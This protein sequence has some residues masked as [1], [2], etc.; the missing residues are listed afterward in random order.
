MIALAA[1][2]AAHALLLAVRFAA[3]EVFRMQP[4]DPGLEVLSLIHI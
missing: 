4:A 1:S 3:P 2:V